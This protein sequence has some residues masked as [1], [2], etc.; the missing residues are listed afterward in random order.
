M[1]VRPANPGLPTVYGGSEHLRGKEH[2]YKAALLNC[3]DS[4]QANQFS[5]SCSTSIQGDLTYL[6]QKVASHGNDRWK[7]NRPEQR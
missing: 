6:R 2:L 5:R 1:R 4:G 7:K 3:T